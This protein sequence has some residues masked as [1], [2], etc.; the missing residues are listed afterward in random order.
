MRRDGLGDG[1]RQRVAVA[2]DVP[3]M[4]RVDHLHAPHAAIGEVRA[5][6]Q[7]RHDVTARSTAATTSAALPPGAPTASPIATIA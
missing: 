1:H 7:R 3:A 2:L 6:E 4:P 5:V